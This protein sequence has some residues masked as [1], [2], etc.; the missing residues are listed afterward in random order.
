MF[1]SL[2]VTKEMKI[3]C[4]EG[5]VPSSEKE[6]CEEK[7]LSKRSCVS[8]QDNSAYGKKEEFEGK[9]LIQ[10]VGRLRYIFLS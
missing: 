7:S 5:F 1:L 8:C 4:A 3:S 2:S 10:K 9:F 6:G